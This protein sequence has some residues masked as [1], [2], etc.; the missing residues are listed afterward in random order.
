MDEN[1]PSPFIDALKSP[2]NAVVFLIGITCLIDLYMGSP[3]AHKLAVLQVRATGADPAVKNFKIVS[4]FGIFPTFE[5]YAR[6]LDIGVSVI[7]LGLSGFY[8]LRG[9]VR[10]WMMR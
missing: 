6:R 10:A 9:L 2:F 8:Y 4:F 5:A 1:E 7:T 3:L